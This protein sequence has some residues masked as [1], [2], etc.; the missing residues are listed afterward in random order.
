MKFEVFNKKEMEEEETVYFALERDEKRI[1]LRQV[2]EDGKKRDF[3]KILWFTPDGK[4]HRYVGCQAKGI[5]TDS[6]GQ[7]LLEE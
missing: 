2:D 1:I 7:I 3:S 5:K 6:D 4:L